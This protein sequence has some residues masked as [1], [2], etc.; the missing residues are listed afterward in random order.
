MRLQTDC[1]CGATFTLEDGRRDDI[2]SRKQFDERHAAWNALHA[3]CVPTVE[4]RENSMRNVGSEDGTSTH[5]THK[6]SL[7]KFCEECPQ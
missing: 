6:V 4:R 5:C 7:D 3:R 2:C 1:C